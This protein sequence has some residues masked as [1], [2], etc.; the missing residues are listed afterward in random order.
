MT[1]QY[2]VPV[3]ECITVHPADRAEL[4]RQLPTAR[5]YGQPIPAGLPIVES[6]AVPPGAIR[7]RINGSDVTCT[8]GRAPEP[9][10]LIA[11]PVTGR[12]MGEVE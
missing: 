8:L 3:P 4:D 5:V 12:P 1:T 6:V 7:I 11:D 10:W 9:R 2:W